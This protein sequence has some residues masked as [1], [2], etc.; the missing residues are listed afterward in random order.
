MLTKSTRKIANNWY[1][2]NN[3][4]YGIHIFTLQ[5]SQYAVGK[6]RRQ[7]ELFSSPDIQ[8]ITSPS[9]SW[10]RSRKVITSKQ[11]KVQLKSCQSNA[12]ITQSCQSNTKVNAII[13]K[14]CKVQRNHIKAM[15]SSTCRCWLKISYLLS[16]HMLQNQLEMKSFLENTTAMTMSISRLPKQQRNQGRW[17]TEQK[18][19]TN[20][21]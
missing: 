5:G 14:Q 19:S 15:Q 4:I 9:Q 16:S 18:A 13:S 8:D 2:K 21:N 10:H 6:S 3:Q 1:S 12:S 20:T 17:F 11:C 7:N